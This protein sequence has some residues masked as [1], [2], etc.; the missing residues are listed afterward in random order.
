MR[1]FQFK[2]GIVKE[3]MCDFCLKGVFWKG[4]C[5]ILGLNGGFSKRKCVILGLNGGLLK[6][7]RTI[8]GLNSKF[9]RE[10]A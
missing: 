9:C 7:K 4:R 6:R 3:G 1:D 2:S 5:V 8:F 10:Y